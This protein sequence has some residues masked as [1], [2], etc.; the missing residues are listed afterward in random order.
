MKCKNCGCLKREHNVEN[1][2]VNDAC[3][4][5]FDCPSFEKYNKKPE[6]KEE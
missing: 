1:E 4:N 3:Q 6:P 5:C 2:S